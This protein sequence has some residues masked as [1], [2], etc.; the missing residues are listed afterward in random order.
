MGESVVTNVV[1]P[2]N[3]PYNYRVGQYLE[4]YIK[5][6]GEKKILGVRCPDCDRVVVPPRSVCCGSD[7][8]GGEW[9]EVGPG[10]TVENFTVAHVK[11][12]LGVPEKL[13]VPEVTALIKLE[14]ADSLIA[15]RVEGVEPGKVED[16]MKVNAVFKDP[17]TDSLEDLDFFEPVG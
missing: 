5:G 17:P 8:S 12:N 13:D 4:R 15:A 11:M 9:V 2:I 10:G 3:F 7:M 6:L 1:V 14:G 16:G